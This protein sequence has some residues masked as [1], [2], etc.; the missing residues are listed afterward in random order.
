MGVSSS[1]REFA[2]KL[3]RFGRELNNVH[4]PLE[5]TALHVKQIFEASAASSGA[6][7]RS[8]KGK[9]KVIGARYDMRAKK[10]A[11]GQVIITYTGPAHLL[12]NPTKPHFIGA[13]RL[14]SRRRLS[15]LSAGVG[16]VSAFGG[17]NRGVFGG[18]LPAERVTRSGAVRSG[19]K[20]A[21]TI[22]GN[23]RAY[24]FHP[25]TRG[26]DFFSRAKAIAQRTAP[27]VYAQKQ[28][29]E[30]LRRVF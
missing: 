3:D 2:A 22:G 8:L 17:S 19:G 29:T 10:A 12:N 13:R 6:L 30:P 14:G 4:I 25:G 5:A 28:L 9:R 24:A 20:Q 23:L 27:H 7:G 15:G 18:L 21:L 16:A 1:P 11:E 26:K